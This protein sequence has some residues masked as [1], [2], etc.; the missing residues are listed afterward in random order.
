MEFPTV[1]EAWV[2]SYSG[3]KIDLIDPKPDSI[4]PIDIA[5]SLSMQ[6]R[7]NGHISQF[8]SVAEHS[9]YVSKLFED[10][11]LEEN[12][13]LYGLL[14]DAAEAYLGDIVSPLKRL[15]SDYSV[16]EKRFQEVIFEKF[17]LDPELPEII[18]EVDRRMLATEAKQLIPIEHKDWKIP[19]EPYRV[20]LP[21]WDPH[22]AEE[23]FLIQ[24][25]RV[26][27]RI[28]FG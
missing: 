11:Y 28:K 16:I 27:P 7:Y 6:C 2:N 13:A 9:V 4:L 5:H 20:V 21:C 14:H 15:I 17:G 22:V 8:Y 3:Q 1:S 26:G 23:E 25:K 19:F 24:L 18:Y 10:T 12:F